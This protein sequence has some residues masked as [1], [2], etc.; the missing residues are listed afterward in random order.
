MDPNIC[1][2]F[3]ECCNNILCPICIDYNK[4]KLKKKPQKRKGPIQD[5][6]KSEKKVQKKTGGRLTPASGAFGIKGDIQTKDKIVEVKSTSKP[7]ISLKGIWLD[8]LQTQ[9]KNINKSFLLVLSIKTRL[10]Y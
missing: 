1:V 4:L 5:W 10:F 9:A 6:K 3:K 7:Y 8:N 2:Y